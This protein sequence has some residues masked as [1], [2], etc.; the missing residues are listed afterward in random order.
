MSR[1]RQQADEPQ[2]IM[3]FGWC[4]RV[5]IHVLRA[6]KSTEFVLVIKRVLVRFV[7]VTLATLPG[8]DQKSFSSTK[9]RRELQRTSS[10]GTFR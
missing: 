7:R 8:L 3:G 9:N 10:F 1:S 6:I 4:V 5:K 2:S